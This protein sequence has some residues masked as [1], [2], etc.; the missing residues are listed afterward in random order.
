M[1]EKLSPKEKNMK[2][3]DFEKVESS[4][5]IYYIFH[6]INWKVIR[7]PNA[8]NLQFCIKFR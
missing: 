1:L 8:L 6:P 3:A 7:K 4:S 5:T 2:T